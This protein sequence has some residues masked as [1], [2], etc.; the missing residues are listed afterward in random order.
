MNDASIVVNKSR[1]GHNLRRLS[2]AFVG[3]ALIMSMSVFE[4]MTTQSASAASFSVVTFA[5]NA[6]P[7]DSTVAFQT[8]I[9]AV[10][11]TLFSNLSPSFTNPGYTF[12]S[13][14]TVE[15]GGGTTYTD[16]AIYNFAYG[17]TILYAQ[18]ME[19]SVTFH[20]NRSGVDSVTASESGT[21]IVDLTNFASLTPS[22]SNP[23]FAFTEW[24]TSPNGAGTSYGDGSQYNLAQGSVALYA[25]WTPLPTE[26]ASFSLSGGS[27]SVAPVAGSQGSQVTLPS[28]SG[29]SNPGYTFTGW[30]TAADGSGTEYA[31]GAT[32][33][34]TSD[35]T[36]YAQWAPDVYTV[37]YAPGSGSVVPASAQYTVGTTGLVLPAPTYSGYTFAGWYTAISGG[38][39]VGLAGTTFS[40]T[41]D[42]TLYAQWTAN[43]YTVTY[44]ASG[45]TVSPT[46]STFT[47]GGAALS[48]PTPSNGLS[49]FLGW[50]T[51]PSGGTL[52]GLAG[53]SYAPSKDLTLY[54]Q[55]QA[56]AMVTVTFDPNGGTG[57]VAPITAPAGSTI[58]IPGV[59]GL[60]KP[61][62]TLVTWSTAKSGTGTTYTTG[63]SMTVTASVT[64]YAVWVGKPPAVL[65]G[66]VGP[67]AGRSAKLTAAMK[68]QIARL[69]AKVKVKGFATVTV[70]GY[71]P[72]V[73]LASLSTSISRTR[74][75]A[76]ASYLR[77]RLAALH[78]HATI[79][80]AGEGFVPGGGSTNARVEVLGR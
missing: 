49:T 29:L 70:Y 43:T 37:T 4:G 21:G 5:E 36:L 61:G 75:T 31:S 77:R 57:T 48:L 3:L 14:N 79:K 59:S 20:E 6:T 42:V 69:A 50:F 64:L 24:T 62:Y 26:T 78:V 67:F 72:S 63:S 65:L 53:A 11:L 15:N 80:A 25:Q 52:V 44:D 45:G 46:A 9:G 18:W 74:A 30:N 2:A 40:P 23:G 34:L 54:A 73:G 56:P 27:G 58:T 66:A 17:D 33:T 60:L 8:E 12:T 41:Q 7:D 13:W 71:A 68:A 51:A 1:T 76:V 19:N 32:I 10:P 35:L 38:A 16:G 22:F 39:L 47:T 28:G 55:W